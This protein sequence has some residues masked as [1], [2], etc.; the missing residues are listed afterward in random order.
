MGYGLLE[1]ED[2]SEWAV[3]LFKLNVGLFENDG[4][5]WDS[6]GDGYLANG[7]REEAIES[8][9]RALELDSQATAPKLEALLQGDHT[10]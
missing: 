7:Q 8:Y 10:E 4:N 3:E 9:K 6:L 1:E 5:L 2:N